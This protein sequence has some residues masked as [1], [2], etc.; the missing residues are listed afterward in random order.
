MAV[1]EHINSLTNVNYDD[2]FEIDFTKVTLTPR[3]GEVDGKEMIA[4]DADEDTADM[5][6]AL[7]K[8]D[9]VMFF[10]DPRMEYDVIPGI[11]LTYPGGS[12]RVLWTMDFTEDEYNHMRA[13]IKETS[14]KEY[15]DAKSYMKYLIG[16]EFEIDVKLEIFNWIDDKSDL[17]EYIYQNHKDDILVDGFL[18]TDTDK[19]IDLFTDVLLPKMIRGLN[20]AD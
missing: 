7:T 12:Y 16:G 19:V 17:I 11:Y 2:A 8:C 9:G 6:K 3:K 14:G 5:I 15:P 13:F 1:Y 20:C 4:F 10:C 18:N